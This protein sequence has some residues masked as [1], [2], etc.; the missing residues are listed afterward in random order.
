MTVNLYNL[1]KERIEILLNKKKL[2]KKEVIDFLVCY[3]E[4]HPTKVKF[5]RK[6]I[7]QVFLTPWN[8]FKL[9][10]TLEKAR[11]FYK[12]MFDYE[13]ITNTSNRDPES[14]NEGELVYSKTWNLHVVEDGKFKPV[15][16]YN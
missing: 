15:N 12:R 9:D 11:V 16:Y 8:T 2:S 1:R 3:H 4:D 7:E 5:T 6:E 13:P 14:F 10:Y